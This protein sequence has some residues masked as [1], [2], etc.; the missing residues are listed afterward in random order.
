MTVT[1]TAEGA[2]IDLDDDEAHIAPLFGFET[3]GE[4]R[5]V[6]DAKVLLAGLLSQ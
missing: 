4:C 1:R 2:V 3:D 6:I 5:P